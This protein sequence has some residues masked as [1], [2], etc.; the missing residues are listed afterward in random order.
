MNLP[1]ERPASPSPTR[2]AE[3]NSLAQRLEQLHEIGIALSAE[4]DVNR[5][6]EKILAHHRA[7]DPAL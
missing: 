3:G 7:E 6:L 2:G 1:T 4:R 5:L